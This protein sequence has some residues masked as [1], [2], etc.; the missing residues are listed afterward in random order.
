MALAAAA[1]LPM[2]RARSIAMFAL[3]V[4]MS[5]AAAAQTR[6]GP[7]ANSVDSSYDAMLDR[8]ER[9]YAA[10]RW[11]EAAKLYQWTL[12]TDARIPGH[13]WE[14]GHALFN[15]RRHREAIAAY[16]R[17]LQLGVGEPAAGSWQIARAYAHRGNRKQ[18]LRW[19]ARAV[20]L[21]FDGKEAI[22]QEPLFEQYR[23]DPR[24]SAIADSSEAA[25]R[26]LRRVPTGRTRHA[27][28]REIESTRL[29]AARALDAG[30]QTVGTAATID[31]ALRK[32]VGEV[33]EPDFGV[34]RPDG[35]EL[36]RRLAGR[37]GGEDERIA[38]CV[39]AG[40]LVL[41]D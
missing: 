21:G 7:T 40:V 1:T 29:A 28:V 33:L 24:F 34:D 26:S 37:S 6:G 32:V 20:D 36:G 30:E 39:D 18:A 38:T 31:D 13:W 16:E 14:L 4:V 8:A 22:R 23:G 11:S 35:A 25:R 17:A 10:G 3:A 27:P 19:L 5:R 9:A 2:R 12:E 41:D 15:A